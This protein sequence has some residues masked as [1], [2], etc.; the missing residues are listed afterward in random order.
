MN[1]KELTRL[2]KEHA[3]NVQA[4][5]DAGTAVIITM[6]KLAAEIDN[7]ADAPLEGSPLYM[8]CEKVTILVDDAFNA[9]RNVLEPD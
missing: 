8:K 7:M 9:V 4:Y 1:N 5:M 6:A 3:A 2:A